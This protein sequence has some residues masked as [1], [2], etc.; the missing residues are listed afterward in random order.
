MLAG[1]AL[2]CCYSSSV[3][4]VLVLIVFLLL[5]VPFVVVGIVVFLLLAVPFIF[6]GTGAGA[7]VTIF[8]AQTI[9][10]YL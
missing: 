4:L 6:V 9:V 3:F 8:V 7:G 5:A 2:A 10:V 1:C